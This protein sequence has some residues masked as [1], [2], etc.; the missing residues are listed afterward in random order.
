[1]CTKCGHFYCAATPNP[2]LL[3]EREGLC[4]DPA[5][6]GSITNT[7]TEAALRYSLTFTLLAASCVVVALGAWNS[8]GLGAA[9]PLYAAL[10]FGLVGVAYAGAS[11][12][13]LLKRADGRRSVF[14]WLLFAPY[15]L[16]NA[17]TFSFYRLLSREPAYA[18]VAPNLFFGR[19]LS[20]REAEAVGCMSVLDLTAEFPACWWER[21]LSGGYRSLPV[22]DA[23]APSLEELQSATAWVA[24]VL[25]AGPVYIHCALG[26]GRSACVVIA[27][28][29]S[30]KAVATVAAGE[31]M[32]Q[33]LR[34]G[35]RLDPP[36]ARLLRQF[37]RSLDSKLPG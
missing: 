6:S 10:S 29:L 25:A 12:R 24:E 7:A 13:I 23:S 3:V 11:P 15:F 14:G 22:L 30:V 32:L 8:I 31:R 18:Q 19:R 20:T 16:L 36:Q 34:P 35:V 4:Y 33:C 2:R 21:T 28:L 26:H 17:L 1:L 9:L 37:E 27:Y 5:K